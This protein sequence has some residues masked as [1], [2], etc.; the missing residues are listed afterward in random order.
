MHKLIVT[1]QA[2]RQS[3]A[4]DAKL[5][6]LDPD[7]RLIGR[8]PVRR[9]HPNTR[10]PLSVVDVASK[11]SIARASSSASTG[12]TRCAAKPARAAMALSPDCP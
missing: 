3:S 7:N 5:Q 6:D 9:L 1:S 4:R 11:V 2:Y 8:M 10:Q 12:L